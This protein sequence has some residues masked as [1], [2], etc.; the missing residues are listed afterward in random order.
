MACRLEGSEASV[1]SLYGCE[2]SVVIVTNM[3]LSS[4]SISHRLATLDSTNEDDVEPVRL[5]HGEIKDPETA[6]SGKQSVFCVYGNIPS[7]LVVSAGMIRR[8]WTF[9]ASL[10]PVKKQAENAF[11]YGNSAFHEM[12]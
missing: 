6:T 10:H 2:I 5:R 9:L 12:Q 4:G 8:R 3:N 1:I 11:Q 7:T